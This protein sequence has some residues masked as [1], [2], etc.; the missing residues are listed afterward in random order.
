MMINCINV[1]N[2]KISTK[3]TKMMFS[4]KKFV[5]K[6]KKKI[7]ITIK[8]NRTKMEVNDWF[9]TSVFIPNIILDKLKVSENS[10]YVKNKPNN[11]HVQK[12]SMNMNA[13]SKIIQIRSI[14]I[15]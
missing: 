15:I 1:F 2:Q 12:R 3:N 4:N 14:D 6:N 7:A 10:K 8:R 11:K 5:D 13:Q 9:L